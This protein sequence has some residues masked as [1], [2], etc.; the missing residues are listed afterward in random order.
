MTFVT[1]PKTTGDIITDIKTALV[2]K[3]SMVTETTGNF[4]VAGQEVP[5]N[6]KTTFTAAYK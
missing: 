1:T 2:K 6:A 5:I 3:K 4:Q